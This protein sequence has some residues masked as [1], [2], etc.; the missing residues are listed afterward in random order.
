MR[1]LISLLLAIGSF[2]SAGGA[3]AE[4]TLDE[5]QQQIIEQVMDEIIAGI[6]ALKEKHPQLNRFGRMPEFT[7]GKYEFRY[8]FKLK[9]TTSDEGATIAED[10][11]DGC[12]IFFRLAAAGAP[13]S[14]WSNYYHWQSFGG[15]RAGIGHSLSINPARP[16]G[17]RSDHPLRI[18]V[19][20]VVKHSLQTT[21]ERLTSEYLVSKQGVA[22]D[23]K[24]LLDE[25][26]KLNSSV[27]KQALTILS[28]RELNDAELTRIRRGFRDKRYSLD[29]GYTALQLMQKKDQEHL[30]E[31]YADLVRITIDLE[32]RGG[33]T[34]TRT[35]FF[36]QSRASTGRGVRS[37][38][39]DNIRKLKEDRFL[40]VARTILSEDPAT[41][42][43]RTMLEYLSELKS[44]DAQSL[45]IAALAN[46]FRSVQRRA[47]EIAGEQKVKKAVSQL[48]TLMNS[49]SSITRIKAA[50]ALEKLNALNEPPPPREGGVP[51]SGRRIAKTLWEVGLSDADIMKISEL[52][53][54]VEWK[55]TEVTVDTIRHRAGLFPKQDDVARPFLLAAALKLEESRLAQDIYEAMCNYT[56]SDTAVLDRAVT[57]L[58][59]QR[60]LTG[61]DHFQRKQDKAALPM[62]EAVLS[63]KKRAKPHSRLASYVAQSETLVPEIKARL[64]TK[65]ADAPDEDDRDAYI[66]FW[67]AQIKDINGVQPGQ[68]ATPSIW[69]E[70]CRW[71][72]IPQPPFASDR[73]R[74]IG[75]TA[76]PSLVEV[77]DDQTPT[78]TVGYWRDFNPTRYLV[79]VGTAAQRV[80]YRICK[81]HGLDP[82]KSLTNAI[83]SRRT[84][85][86]AVLQDE[87]RQWLENVER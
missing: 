78:R 18:D 80:F 66:N 71:S 4:E 41:Q 39:V 19:H 70:E 77:M 49:P 32:L 59:W 24:S 36:G 84:V 58:A 14:K 3:L 10:S 37:A 9:E 87:L 5:Q 38:V 2:I 30:P 12:G 40:S 69:E 68:P 64:K 8:H 61:F 42:N 75:K 15:G 33:D 73:L 67:I 86:V 29:L 50:E 28:F 7:R 44:E 53:G 35:P 46:E 43:R 82:P 56:E 74:S 51:A 63:T 25:A 54:G 45:M 34:F 17:A 23:N 72:D 65:K 85:K 1:K 21:F 81:D 48:E 31:F 52:R 83:R 20:Q 26:E 76:L 57:D 6:E 47:A 11:A 22:L 60:M 13:N 62:F 55:M 27:T 79:T 16:G